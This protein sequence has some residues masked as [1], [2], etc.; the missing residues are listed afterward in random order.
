VFSSPLARADFFFI[1]CV[2]WPIGEVLLK[3]CPVAFL[4]RFYFTLDGG[5]V[6]V[7]CF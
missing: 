5:S 3:E 4:R 7:P 1:H 2:D 6:P